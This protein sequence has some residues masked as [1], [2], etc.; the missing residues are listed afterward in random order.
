MLRKHK[1]W[2]TCRKP[3]LSV[4]SYAGISQSGFRGFFL[5]T[6]LAAPGMLICKVANYAAYKSFAHLLLRGFAASSEPGN[7]LQ[8]QQHYENLYEPGHRRSKHF[9]HFDGG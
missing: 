6:L 7:Q 5:A 2:Q 4:L 9:A 8:H 3:S 1:I